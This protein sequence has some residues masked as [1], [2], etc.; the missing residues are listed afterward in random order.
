MY[1]VPREGVEIGGE[2]GDEGFAF[3][4]FHFGDTPLMENNA[5]DDL[6]PVRAHTEHTACRLPADGELFWKKLFKR[7]TV[8]QAA[9]KFLCFIAK[10]LVGERFIFLFEIHYGI[11]RGV[12]LFDFTLRAGAEHFSQ[13]SHKYSFP[14]IPYSI[15]F[16]L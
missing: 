1:A 12:N 14:K 9:L 7:L 15:S 6:H 16:V 2:N 3:A 5:A 8:L 11:D 10:L 13:K 4:R